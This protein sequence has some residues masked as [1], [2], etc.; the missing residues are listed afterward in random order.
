MKLRS[1]RFSLLALAPLLAVLTLTAWVFASPVG[2]G[3]DDDYHLISAWCV[4]PTAED[5]CAPNVSSNTYSVPVGLAEIACFAFEPTKSAAC[6]GQ[7][8]SWTTDALV[9]TERTNFQGLYPPIYYAV[10][11]ALTGD[12]I[13]VSALL[14]RML[15]VILFV[16]IAVALHILLPARHR[17]TFIWGWLLTSV[18]LGLFLFGTNNPSVWAWIGVGSTWI[19]LLGYYETRGRRKAALGALF[20]ITA[21]MGAGSR[22]D[23]ALFTGFAIALVMG[24]SLVRHR[25]FLRDSILP[26]AVGLSALALFLP[27]Y[28]A[29]G[30][31]QGFTGVRYD[32]TVRGS[33]FDPSE[34]SRVA[35]PTPTPGPSVTTPID[36]PGSEAPLGGA[37]PEVPVA[38]PDVLDVIA[39]PGP[40][41]G[42]PPLEGFGLFAS[43]LL[44]VPELWT[45]SLGGWALGW[46]DTSMPALV[47]AMTVA[48]FVAVGFLG[49]AQASMRKAWALVAVIVVLAALPVLVL[50]AGGDTV[51]FQFQARYL[52]PLIVLLAGLMMMTTS[53]QRVTLSLAQRVTVI[54][55]LSA[56]HFVALHLNI[57]RYVTGVDQSGP[58]LDAGAEWWWQGPIG[59]NAVWLLGSL[60]YT[61]LIAI[62]I[63]NI[64]GTALLMR[65]GSAEA[66]NGRFTRVH[67]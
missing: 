42:Q 46:L 53:T 7:E 2:A 44:N 54:A 67:A 45:G 22:A 64:A 39:T 66:V 15:T 37:A 20:A 61:L 24:L 9:N 58:N 4:G 33:T 6:Q 27:T 60:A 30:G 62:L 47:P 50:Q 43:N 28:F 23:A 21:L 13:Q 10:T 38:V 29:R 34:G 35:G 31:A 63:T 56:A 59:P 26:I 32:D 8:W 52:L 1:R 48:A 40:E 3:P 65:S 49:L 12:D 25:R 55:A 11:G 14:M 57:R 17:P 16:M 19:A 18:P 36:G 5:T 51:G 41:A